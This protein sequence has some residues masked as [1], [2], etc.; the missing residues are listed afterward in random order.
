VRLKEMAELRRA[1][2]GAEQMVARRLLSS[3]GAELGASLVV[4][5]SIDGGR[6]LARVVRTAGAAS[7]RVELGATI[8]VGADGGKSFRWPGV[9][10]TLRGL[11]GIAEPA[12]EPVG[13][14]ASKAPAP[15]PPAPAG[16]R[17]FYKSPWF[18]GTA[19]VV[20]AAGITVLVLSRTT[21]GPGDVHVSGRVGQ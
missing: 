12:V 3:I 14:L 16:P 18:W 15:A 10:A 6:P 1:A 9:A 5:V 13:P 20:A 17:P 19:G 11:L 8:E 2:S 21:A 7:E 4:T